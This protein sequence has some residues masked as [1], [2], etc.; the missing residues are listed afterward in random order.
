KI[1]GD[2]GNEWFWPLCG[3]QN[4]NTVWIYL[5]TQRKKGEGGPW[6]FESTGHDYWGKVALRAMDRISYIA[7]P[8]FTGISFGHGLV[9]DGYVYAFGGKRR[10]LASDIYV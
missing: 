7:L 4:G 6:G 3:I 9:K 2:G 8:H 10:G 1:S 5:S